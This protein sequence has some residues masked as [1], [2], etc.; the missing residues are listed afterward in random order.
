MFLLS[1]WA[2]S[3]KTP[4][5]FKDRADSSMTMGYADKEKLGNK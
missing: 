3:K 5:F 1:I 4:L 2:C